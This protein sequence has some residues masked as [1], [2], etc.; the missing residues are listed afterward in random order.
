[1]EFEGYCVK[2]K[3]KTKAI[4]AQEVIMKNGRKALKGKCSECSTVMFKILGNK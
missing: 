1:M 3:K 2:Q 4:E